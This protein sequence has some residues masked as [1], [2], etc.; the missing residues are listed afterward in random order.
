MGI[1]HIVC[2][3]LRPDA[4]A[5]AVSAAVD[6]ALDLRSAEGARRVL[7]GRSSDRLVTVTWL[8]SRGAL[9]A[10]AASPAHMSFIMRGLAPC[11]RGMWSASVES[12]AP[13][14][15]EVEALWV[16]AVRA[17]D[18]LFEWQIR[19]LLASLNALPGTAA[20][21]PT[22]EERERYRAGGAVCVAPGGVDAFAA[23]LDA[24]RERWGDV[25]GVLD[26][27]L[28]PLVDAGPR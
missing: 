1:V 26:D 8:E 21:G 2:A 27:V 15:V 13:P 28:A 12:A 23:A 5:G 11:I 19:D 7:V 14:P 9:E 25:A 10:F 22:I 18:T 17:S 24:A 3:T 4:A 16:F 6:R 20:A